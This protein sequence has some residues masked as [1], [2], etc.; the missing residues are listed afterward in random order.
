[1]TDA[2]L[3]AMIAV[4]MAHRGS[5][6]PVHYLSRAVATVAGAKESWRTHLIAMEQQREWRAASRDIP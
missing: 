3:V 1:M 6:E 5:L 4:H 2:Q